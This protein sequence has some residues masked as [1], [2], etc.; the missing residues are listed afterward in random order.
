MTDYKNHQPATELSTADKV[1]IAALCLPIICVII[2]N[3]L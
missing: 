1:G 3:L 2:L